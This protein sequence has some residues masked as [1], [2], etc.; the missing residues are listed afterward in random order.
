MVTA[1]SGF[2]RQNLS[3]S[4]CAGFPSSAPALA[5]EGRALFILPR[6]S[7]EGGPRVCAVEGAR[8][9]TPCRRFKDIAAPTLIALRRQRC[10]ES[11]APST[12]LRSLRELRRSPSPA[13]AVAENEAVLATHRIRDCAWRND[14]KSSLYAFFYPLL[15]FLFLF[16]NFFFAQ[17]SKEA[18]RRQTRS[19]RAVPRERMS[20]LARASGPARAEAQR[21]HLSA[22]RR[23]ACCSERT[24]Q[25]NS[26]DALPVTVLGR[27]GRYPLPAVVQCSDV[28]RTGHSAGR[29]SDPESPG[30]EGDEP[31]PAG[32]ALAPPTGITRPASLL[33]EM[34]RY[35][36]ITGT[37]SRGLSPL[38]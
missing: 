28:S 3:Y 6:D 1:Y 37:M 20:P 5:G 4:S 14:R 36:T 9:S 23:G 12:I 31:P 11:G 25:L 21:A 27:S 30:S 35:V 7:G 2:A 38:L 32:T 22:F 8:A 10:G 33:G 16:R 34:G 17:K 19:P 15:Y 18:E 24:P 26:S 13:I 29:A